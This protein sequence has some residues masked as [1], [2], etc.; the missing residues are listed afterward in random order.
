MVYQCWSKRYSLWICTIH[1][2]LKLMLNAIELENSYHSLTEMMVCDRPSKLCMIHCC[3]NCSGT[4]SVR[5]FLCNHFFCDREFDV[6]DESN[7]EIE[8]EF[9]QWTTVDRT[10]L[11]SMKLSATEFIDLLIQ[12]LDEITVHLFNAPV[13]SAYLNNLKETIGPDE[14]IVLGEFVKNYSF[15]IQDEVQGYH[16]NKS[17]CSLHPSVIYHQSENAL[18]Q[19]SICILSDDVTH[20]VSFVYKVMEAAV[21]FIKTRLIPDIKTIHYFSD[22]CAGQYK[23]QKHFYN[24]CF[25]GSDFPVDCEWNIFATSHGKSLCDGIGGTVKRVTARACLQK[26][27]SAHILTAEQ[28]FKLYKE[29]IPSVNFVYITENE[30][31][32]A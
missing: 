10:E 13:Q 28:M 23:N 27:I 22:G 6:D 7:V 3:D 30:I 2:N 25:H 14:A 12:K 17:Q 20:D 21:E 31:N 26:T 16:W 19:A 11:I 9:Q 32:T 5:D 18:I 8:D 1:Q 24:L 29:V 4:V 15:I